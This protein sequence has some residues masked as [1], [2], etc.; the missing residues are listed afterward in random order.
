MALNFPSTPATSTT[1]TFNDKTWT[2]NGNAW[3]LTSG[4]SLT[5]SLIPEGINLYF[6]NARAIAAIVNSSLSNITVA[7]NVSTSNVIVTGDSRLGTVT[8]GNWNGTSI[9]TAYTDAKIISVSNT[10]P[11]SATTTTGAVTIGLLTSGVTAG[12]YGGTTVEGVFT[13][14][15]YGRITSA[16]NVTAQVANSNITGN[17]IASQLQPTGVTATTY[18]GA[19]NIPA[20]TIDAQ[21]RI[22]SAY[23]VAITPGVTTGKSIAMAIVFGG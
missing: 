20:I 3:A 1:Y 8:S 2:Y 12:T 13:V 19:S 18:G 23:N 5:T 6:S 16:S 15:S 10:A 14:D 7:G 11:I 21:G 9:S 4:G 22:T 17:I